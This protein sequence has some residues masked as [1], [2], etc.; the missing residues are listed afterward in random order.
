MGKAS[1]DKGS[2]TE[3]EV[4]HVFREQGFASERIPL[5]GGTWLK[6]DVT[7]P[8]L[9]FD[10]QLEVKCRAKGF[11][12]VYAWLEGNYALI[13]KADRSEPLIVMPLKEAAR[14]A[15]IAEKFKDMA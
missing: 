14:I 15:A 12:Q 9:N 8:F 13:V 5:S 10:R 11:K 4:V 2:R 6:G 1:R 3:R 7:V